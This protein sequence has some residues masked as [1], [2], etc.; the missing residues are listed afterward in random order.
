MR[1]H[2][3]KKPFYIPIDKYFKRPTFKKYLTNLRRK[4]SR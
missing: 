1:Y 4:L 2:I 3:D